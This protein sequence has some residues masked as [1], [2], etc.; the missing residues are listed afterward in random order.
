MNGSQSRNA[1]F[2]A[3]VALGANLPSSA[4]APQASLRFALNRIA[5]V[6]GVALTAVSRFWIT[7]AHPRGS[8]PD[9]VNAAAALRTSLPADSLLTHLHAIESELG[10]ERSG[11]RWQARGLDLDLLAVED[12]VCPDTAQHDRWRL[13]PPDQQPLHAPQE[14]ILPHPRLQDRGFVLA[15]LAE[16][17]PNWCHPRLGLGVAQMLAALPAEAMMDIRPATT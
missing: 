6:P 10:R 8:G 15:P 7:P 3:L 1:P 16:I 2:L 9:Y 4:G 14:L 17:A 12:M 13:L 5:Q 11:A